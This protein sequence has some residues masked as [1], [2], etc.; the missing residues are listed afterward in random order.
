MEGTSL[1]ANFPEDKKAKSLPSGEA[2][3]LDLWVLLVPAVGIEPTRPQGTR[4]FE[5]FQAYFTHPLT[6]PN[7]S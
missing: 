2:P 4:D 3:D 7:Y 1:N 5:S 6:L